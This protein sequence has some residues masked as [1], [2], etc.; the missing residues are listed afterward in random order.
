MYQHL[1]QQ[2]NKIPLSFIFFPILVPTAPINLAG[3]ANGNRQSGRCAGPPF[4]GLA[5][6]KKKR[7]AIR[8]CFNH[9]VNLPHQNGWSIQGDY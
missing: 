7:R 9:P 8:L 5:E 1:Q 4:L 3:G 6:E 2:K